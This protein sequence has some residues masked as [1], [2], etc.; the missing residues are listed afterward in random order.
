MNIFKIILN[1]TMLI[2][3]TFSLSN[4]ATYW[5]NRKNDFQDI[6][7][8]GIEKPGFGAGVRLGPIAA[9]FVFQGGMDKDLGNVD[10]G[11]GL[12]G[13][14]LGKYHSR[15]LIFGLLGGETFYAGDVSEDELKTANKEKI[16]PNLENERD[17]VKSHK[18]RYLS[19]FND[20]VDERNN[21]KKEA[22]KKALLDKIIAVTGNEELR[23][24]LPEEK[25]K[26]HGYPSSYLLQIDVFFA[27]YYG[28]RVGFNIG[29]LFDLILGFT[30][31]DILEDDK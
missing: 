23:A 8:I 5:Q 30:G 29:E 18:V 17:N 15:Q 11:Y 7:T 12:R 4:C 27:M 28:I 26:I 20:R 2:F 3:L 9:G 14:H 16:L 6:F 24:T 31:I 25:A 10:A 1:V 21:R 19:F 22:Y 13:G